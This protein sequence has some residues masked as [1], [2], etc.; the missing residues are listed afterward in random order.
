MEQ[1]ERKGCQGSI[2]N[3][4][5]IGISSRNMHSTWR[6]ARWYLLSEGSPHSLPR[7]IYKGRKKNGADIERKG[8]NK[9]LPSIIAS[10]E[11]G[12]HF[13]ELCNQ[14]LL[15]MNQMISWKNIDELKVQ[16]KKSIEYFAALRKA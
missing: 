3:K 6:I 1:D 12:A 16:V 4:D 13:S 9:R 2:Y 5:S 15:N 8:S 11:L 14:L 7:L 10:F